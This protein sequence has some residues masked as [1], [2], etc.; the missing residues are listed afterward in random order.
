M[1]YNYLIYI[2]RF[3]PFHNG[4]KYIIEEG[5]KISNNIIVFCGSSNQTR[6]LQ[7]PFTYTERRRF[8]LN[9]FSELYMNKIQIA[10]LDDCEN[11]IEWIKKV[12]KKVQK[13]VG[14]SPENRVALIGHTKDNSSYYLK[15]F[16]KWKYFE[17]KNF[18][19][20]NAT[21][22]RDLIFTTN[23]KYQIENKIK[24]LV[25]SEVLKFILDFL[26]TKHYLDLQ[27]LYILQNA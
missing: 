10:P 16:E 20:I 27:N 14:N 25:P 24:K 6:T 13:I 17:I 15:L 2:G 23:D 4:H 7:N 5:L 3:Q 1:K 21:Y 12:E 8:I 11:D 9:S 26:D 22:I 19:E 18:A